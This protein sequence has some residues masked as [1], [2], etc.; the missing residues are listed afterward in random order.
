[1]LVWTREP[2]GSVPQCQVVIAGVVGLVKPCDTEYS[3]RL[4]KRHDDLADRLDQL[5]LPARIEL[6]QERIHIEKALRIHF[7]SRT[8]RAEVLAWPHIGRA[9]AV[10]LQF[11]GQPHLRAVVTV[12]A[13]NLG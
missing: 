1:M 8:K 11:S 3:E 13:F 9:R 2:L 7:P 5:G 4:R 10:A 6:S 12:T